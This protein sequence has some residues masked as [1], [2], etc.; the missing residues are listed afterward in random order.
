MRFNS[1]HLYT[2]LTKY[3]PPDA[4]DAPVFRTRNSNKISNRFTPN[5]S[6]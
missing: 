6:N 3:D 4:G 1:N 2:N 5:Y